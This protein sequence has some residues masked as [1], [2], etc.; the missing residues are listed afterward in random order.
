M[1]FTILCQAV[2][3]PQRAKAKTILVMKL[4]AV[5]IL[6][7]FLQVTAAGFSQTVTISKEN[8]PL[9]KLFREIKKQTGYVFFY[10]TRLLQK[11]H[12]VNIDVTN[13]NLKEVLDQVFAAQPVTYSIINKTVVVNE[14]KDAPSPVMAQRDTIPVVEVRGKVLNE[15]SGTPVVGANIL[16]RG[17]QLGTSTDV[18]G[19]F[20]I[21]ARSG[22]ILVISYVG[23]ESQQVTVKEGLTA[24]VKLKANKDPLADVVITGYQQIK[25]ESFTGNAVVVTGEE[26]KRIN[27]TNMLQ[28]IQ[29][30][31]PSF[32]IAQ[33]NILG[34]NP[35]ALPKINVR[36][37]ASLPTGS[38]DVLTRNNLKSNINL[39]TFILD[40][41]EVSVEKVFDL[42]VNRVQTITLLKD[43]AATAV[44]GS[45]AANGVLVITTK[46]PQEGKLQV[47]YSYD[48]TVS[49]PDLTDYH[50]LNAADKLEYERLAGLY[51][52]VGDRSINEQEELYYKKKANVLAGVN[53]YWLSQ[54]VRTALGHKNSLYLEGG[55]AAIRYGIDLRYQTQPGVMKRSGRDRY[56][57]GSVISYAPTK[58]II[59]RNTLTVT[60]VTGNES[61]YGSFAGYV[62]MNPYYPKSDSNG[63]ILQAVDDWVIDTRLTDTSQF[64]TNNVLNPAYNGTLN[65]FD[66][67]K[68]IEIIDAFTAEWNITSALRLR[69]LASVT[70]RKYTNDRFYSPLSNQFYDYETTRLR[71]RGSYFYST[72]D[73]NAFDGNITLNYNKQLGDHFINLAGGVNM[74]TFSSDMKSITA[75]GF[76][77][78]RFSNIEFANTYALNS[79]PDAYYALERLFGSFMSLN[80]SYRNKY[81]ADLSGR[82]DGSSKFGNENKTAPFWSLGLGWNVH[83]EDFMMNSPFSTLRLRASTGL[84][85]EVKFEPYQSKTTYDYYT[86]NWYSTGIGATVTTYGNEGLKWQ[87]TD[88]YDAGVDV[89]LFQ[90]KLFVSARYYQKLTH[91]LLADIILPPSTGF[92]SYKEN[93]GDMENTGVELSLR[94]T[95]F[96]NRDWTVTLT[97]N[98]ARNENKILK[99][100]NALKAYNDKIDNEQTKN[101]QATPLLRYREGESLNTIYAVPSL[102]IDPENGKEL[103]VKK[104]GSYTYTWDVKDIVPV[105][106]NTPD[107]YGYFGPNISYKRFLLNVLFYTRFGGKEYNQTLVDRIENADPRY[108]VDSR[109]L[110]DRWKKPGDHALYKDISLTDKTFVSDRFI[111]KDNVLE[112]QS[113]YLSYDFEKSIYSKLA[114]RNLRVAFTMN[115]IWRSSSM[116]VERGIDYPFARSFTFS[117]QTSL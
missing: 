22:A 53:T 51:A 5:F 24:S 37:A 35:N 19:N 102:G 91:G 66:R 56:G 42:D 107:A 54:P 26:L 81:M 44:Y 39:P 94:Y 116:K 98:M 6:A 96:K 47:N 57:I 46:A 2:R 87:K 82:L 16:I 10:N 79:S 63:H 9:Q 92:S 13:S 17:S 49:A 80:Y 112:L 50:V 73:E 95:V 58:K 48:G 68:Y 21:R 55:N 4:T 32:Q 27:P 105:A 1:I 18:D 83:K 23:F 93:L 71:E 75:I 110:S 90:D 99:I 101:Y 20:S 43:A 74:R 65:N 60:Q 59:F 113:V 69:G 29:A 100:S 11:T 36:G 86:S 109:V 97:A 77:N 103:F 15:A 70:K 14:R 34:S 84:T 3:I 33:N 104:D 40:G 72:T 28:S 7:G 114:M 12:P 76:S 115:D 89:G 67:T 52:A 106:D 78:D 62:Q 88:N 38:G 41:F 31:D 108:N 8:I 61:P 111:Q 45:R 85:G 30:Y 117:I 64:K 25:K